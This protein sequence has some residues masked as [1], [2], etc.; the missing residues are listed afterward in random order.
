MCGRFSLTLPVKTIAEFF[1]IQAKS[2]L[3]PRFNIAPT[4][5]VLTVFRESGLPPRQAGLMHWGLIPAWARDKKIV[6]KLTNGRC[7]TLV[8]KPSLRGSYKYRRC[9]I[10]TDGFYE[11]ER[12]GKVK[13]PFYF[14][15]A[16]NRPIAFA[17][18]WEHWSSTE[19]DEI[20]SCTIITTDANPVMAPI[21]HRMPVM[22]DRSD[23]DLWLDPAVN[24]RR[25]L[26]HLLVPYAG[27]DLVLHAVST[28]VNK[29]GNEGPRC[30][31]PIQQP[32]PGQ[33]PLQLNLF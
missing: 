10:P 18:L 24:D 27:D 12:S 4:Q 29:A 13:Q 25:D 17:G 19:G 21:H 8:E 32:P 6:A 16:D 33:D 7:E 22:L 20:T 23:F 30:T 26:A 2:G 14:Y 11:W 15:L 1:M 28:Y 5:P 3:V 9:L 31:A